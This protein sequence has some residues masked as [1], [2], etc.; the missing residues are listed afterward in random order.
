MF[1]L[2]LAPSE[3]APAPNPAPAPQALESLLLAKLLFLKGYLVGQYLHGGSNQRSGSAQVAYSR[4]RSEEHTSELRHITISYAVFCLKKKKKNQKLKQNT[5]HVF[6]H[7]KPYYI[8][9]ASS[10]NNN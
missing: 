7:L 9:P 6:A 2:L 1:A 10:M 5:S 4:H 8:I 3:A